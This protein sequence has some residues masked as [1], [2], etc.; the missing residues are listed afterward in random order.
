[1]KTT[2]V[3][4]LGIVLIITG[5]ASPRSGE[6]GPVY[7]SYEEYFVM[8]KV[9]GGKLVIASPAQGDESRGKANG[10]VG[11]AKGTHGRIVF[12]FEDYQTRMKCTDNKA[13]SAEWVLTTIALSKTGNASTQK[14]RGFGTS[15]TGWVQNAFPGINKNGYLVKDVDLRNARSAEALLNNNSNNGKQVAYY[16]I[17]ARRCD[18]T[19]EP[20][21][22]DP[23]IGN[24]GRR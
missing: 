10:W 17:E 14:G 19:G 22:V 21:K 5:C 23:G 4:I 6:D 9:D 12:A 3:L 16:E 18:G 20:L 2:S 7:N 24:G 1:M 8:L 13:D 15:Q 11:F